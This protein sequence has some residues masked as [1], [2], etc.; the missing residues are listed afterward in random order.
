MNCITRSK[1]SALG[2]MVYEIVEQVSNSTFNKFVV[3]YD[4]V[5]AKVKCQCLLFK[6]RGIL[7]RHALSVLSFERVNK[8]SPRYILEPWRKN[9]KRRHTYIK[10]SHDDPLLEPRSKRFDELVF[11][12]HNICEFA[13]ESEELTTILY[14][15]YDNAMVEMQEHKAKSNGK[16]LLSHEVANLEAI[17]ELQGPPRVE[18]RGC[19]KNRLGSKMEK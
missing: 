3:T 17:N 12:S 8:M 5:V 10:S 15:A 19:P 11:R 9:V 18:T 14:R 13:S 7:C 16:C 1:H 6:S 4:T 2:Y